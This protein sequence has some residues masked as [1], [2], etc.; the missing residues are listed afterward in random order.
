MF[1]IDIFIESRYQADR[2]KIRESARE[3]LKKA[4]LL[5]KVVVSI[6]IIGDRKMAGLNKKY[7]GKEGTTPVLA[8]SQKDSKSFPSNDDVLHLGDVVISY[9]QAIGLAKQNNQLV[10]DVICELVEHGVG[11]LLSI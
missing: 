1:K 9:P 2:K 8:F 5:S 3:T 4:G 6:G 11:K 7:R 10:D